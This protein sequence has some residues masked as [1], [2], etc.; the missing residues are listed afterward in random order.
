[1]LDLTKISYFKRY[2][3]DGFVK[4]YSKDSI[5]IYQDKLFYAVTSTNGEDV[6]S[7]QSTTWKEFLDYTFKFTI[8]ESE[9]DGVKVLGDRWYNPITTMIYTYTKNNEQYVWLSH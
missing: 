3:T 1:M 4:M 9:P 5:V 7:M 2:E 6:P 8:R